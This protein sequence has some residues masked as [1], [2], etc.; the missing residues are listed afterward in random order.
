MH[1]I[2]LNKLIQEICK[3]AKKVTILHSAVKG[4]KFEKKF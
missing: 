3:G 1:L 4:F 2:Y